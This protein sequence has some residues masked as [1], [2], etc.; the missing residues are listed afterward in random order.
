MYTAKN[1]KVRDRKNILYQARQ[2]FLRVL[3]NGNR[4]VY[5]QQEGER[6]EIG[7]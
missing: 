5:G 6:G 7:G 2:G 3:D 4:V 1:E